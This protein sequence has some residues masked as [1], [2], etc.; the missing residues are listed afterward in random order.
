MYKLTI[1]C[2]TITEEDDSIPLNCQY[3]I[4]LTYFNSMYNLKTDTLRELCDILN[5][6]YIIKSVRYC[7]G[8]RK[9]YNYPL[10]SLLIFS[11]NRKWT[12]FKTRFPKFNRKHVT[13]VP[14]K[15]IFRSVTVYTKNASSQC[16][17]SAQIKQVQDT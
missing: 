4:L 14:E 7:N 13:G 9:L 10:I 5:R 15:V 1:Q 17:L 2:K 3:K 16:N 8:C 11:F 12:G 6:H